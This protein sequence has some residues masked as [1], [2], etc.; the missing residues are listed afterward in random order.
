MRIGIYGGSFDPIHYGHLWLA[1]AGRERLHLD[2]VLFL[3]AGI[4]P[5]KRDRDLSSATIRLEM[6][7]LATAGNESFEIDTFELDRPEVSFTVRTL[8]YLEKKYRGHD[9]FLLVGADMLSDLPNWFE[10]SRV[11]QLATPAAVHRMGEPELDFTPL[12]KIVD[13]DR[14]RKIRESRVEMPGIELSSSTLRSRAHD[15]W[16]IRYLVPPAVEQ[17]I[18]LHQL[19]Q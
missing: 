9:L 17:Y 19:Y 11:C 1:E 13:D 6:L 8:E 5:H 16:S 4:P 2:K 18:L 7:R 14:L 3:P 12:G 10:A 15:G